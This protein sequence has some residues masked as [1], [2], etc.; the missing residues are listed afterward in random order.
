MLTSNNLLGNCMLSSTSMASFNDLSLVITFVAVFCQVHGQ[1]G[2]EIGSR[3][4]FTSLHTLLATVDVGVTLNGIA[5]ANNSYVDV[6]DIAIN[7][8]ALLCH[9]NKED[10]CG[11]LPNRFGEWYF[12]NGMKV[13]TEVR[14]QDEFYRDRATRVVR[15]NHRK[16][17]FTERGLFR[18]E[19]PDDTDTVQSVYVNV[20]MFSII[21]SNAI[22]L[23]I[24]HIFSGYWCSST[25]FL[26]WNCWR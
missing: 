9:T 12:P 18:C 24:V 1:S 3:F 8:S 11:K 25:L 16:G 22:N 4:F 23:S 5:I 20:G 13:K 26:C 19:V 21:K 10:C 15:L 6:D 14:T 17:T 2:I 7:M